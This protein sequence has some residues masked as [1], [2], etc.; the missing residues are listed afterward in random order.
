MYYSPVKLSRSITV[1]FLR[2]CGFIVISRDVEVA[3]EVDFASQR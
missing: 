2:I 1:Q 3:D